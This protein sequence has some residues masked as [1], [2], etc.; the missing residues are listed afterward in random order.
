MK[1]KR[2]LAVPLVAV[3]LFQTGYLL[4]KPSRADAYAI[5]PVDDGVLGGQVREALA[6]DGGVSLSTLN[7]KIIH[8]RVRLAGALESRE[9]A[10]RV[11]D[12]TSRVRGVRDVTS[13]LKVSAG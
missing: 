4:A 8:G 7:I 3:T 10:T 2:I 9:Q 13:L 1:I 6:A 12:I 5:V 11:E